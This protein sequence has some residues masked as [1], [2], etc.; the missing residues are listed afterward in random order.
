MQFGADSERY[1][2]CLIAAALAPS[3]V[4]PSLPRCTTLPAAVWPGYAG[5][6]TALGV[7][8]L[9]GSG[10]GPGSYF[11]HNSRNYAFFT[12]NVFDIIEDR[13]S[14][15]LGARYTNER[16]T[17]ES[18]FN[19]T[20]TLCS[21]L[22][23]IGSVA[24]AYPCAINATAGPGFKNGDAGTVI[25]GSK[26]TG[27]AVLSWKPADGLMVYASWARGYKAGGYNLD[28]SALDIVCN[29]A[30]GSAAQQAACAAQLARPIN[31]VGNARP[32]A[33]DLQFGPES[34][35]SYELGAKYSV[36]GFS[37]NIALF[38]QAF[39]NYQLNTYNGVNFEVTNVQACRD[40]LGGADT[41]NSATTG[42]C[43]KDRLQPG[44]I[45]KGVEIEFFAS[46][47]KNVAITGA[48]TYLDTKYQKDLVGTDG[49]PLSPVLFQLPGRQVSNA[50]PYVVTG[51]VSWTPPI[52]DGLRGLVYLDYR[53]QDSTNTGSDLDMEK[54]QQAYMVFNGRVGISSADRKWSLELWGQNIFNKH[55][56]QVAAD[57]PLQGSGTFRAVAD[58]RIASANQLFVMFPGE[59]RT[60]GVTGRF[61]F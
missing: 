1:G 52:G 60:F 4:N 55:Y 22:R 18:A 16:K 56:Q 42:A 40:S 59:P 17:L 36:P 58:G 9:P 57:M 7:P 19:M 6:A 51:S 48:L 25:S 32:E 46:P 11:Q 30:V 44:V 50:P 49:R 24:A 37:A 2:D 23:N 28:T 47:V 35:D 20:N 61:R 27:T 38:R 41:D 29:P 33:V 53:F 14:L 3:T 45:S 8:R 5:L 13:L 31:T 39:S 26:W 12:H 21:A 34:V 10:V 54:V 15:T 43:A